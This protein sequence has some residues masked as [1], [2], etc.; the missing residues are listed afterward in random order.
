METLCQILITL[1]VQFKQMKAECLHITITLQWSNCG[2]INSRSELSDWVVQTVCCSSEMLQSVHYIQEAIVFKSLVI[3]W[4]HLISL[5]FNILFGTQSGPT[6]LFSLILDSRL[7]TSA[8][9]TTNSLGIGYKLIL[10]LFRASHL[11]AECLLS[12]QRKT[13]W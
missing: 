6:A 11:K 8:E 2:I 4:W 5:C 7:Q 12:I 10:S 1:W 13:C 9:V 3:F